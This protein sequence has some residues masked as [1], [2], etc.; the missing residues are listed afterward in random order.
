MLVADMFMSLIYRFLS[1]IN[2]ICEKCYLKIF[3]TSVRGCNSCLQNTGLTEV[4]DE[5]PTLAGWPLDWLPVGQLLNGAP[6][7]E[8]VCLLL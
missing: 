7:T 3:M 2:T 5:P 1:V 6:L 4:G 8:G